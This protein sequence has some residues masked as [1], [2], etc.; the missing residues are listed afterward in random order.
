MWIAVNG[1]KR[2]AECKM[3]EIVHQLETSTIPESS[4]WAV[5]K[6]LKYWLDVFADANTRPRV[7][8]CHRQIVE[9]AT[10]ILSIAG[11][12]VQAPLFFLRLQ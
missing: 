4:S 9:R 10:G 8:Q 1:T 12:R 6:Y 7:G 2:D 5:G 11:G 3:A